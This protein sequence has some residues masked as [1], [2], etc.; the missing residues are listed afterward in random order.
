[1]RRF[2]LAVMMLVLGAAPVLA[3]EP[4]ELIK[5]R[6]LYN[7][8]DY[9]GAIAAASE[10]R[11]QPE[12]A[13]PAAIVQ[14]RAY[15]ERYR[16]R[17]DPSD[18]TAG[19]EA[20]AAVRPDTLVPRD[21]IDLL[22]GMGLYMHL[23]GA[24]GT[25]AD[26]FDSALAQGYLLGGREQLMLLEWWANSLDRSAQARP[27][28]RRQPVYERLMA[29]M[30]REIARDAASP[31]ANYW[32]AVG[33]RGLGDLDRAWDAATAAWVRSRLSPDSAG[34]VRQALDQLVTVLIPE[35]VRMRGGREPQEAA[36]AMREE[37]E[38][39]KEQWP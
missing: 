28:D 15:L 29:R 20:L 8:A 19:R 31:V 13:G 32:L 12:W 21:F 16:Q 17:A 37:W 23:S 39:L 14:G 10:A 36:R 25:A 2:C 18:L 33:A 11:R 26:L 3:A 5:A 7:Q 24:F 6:G 4:P 35:R 9:D 34:E 22:V 27:A 30:E 38:V 1:M